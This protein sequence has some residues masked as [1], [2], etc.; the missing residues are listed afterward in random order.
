MEELEQERR[1]SPL[2]PVV[3]GGALVV[4]IGLLARRKGETTAE[5]GSPEVER[6]AM[7][8]VMAAERALGREPRDVAADKCGYDIESRVPDTGRLLFIEVKGRTATADTVCI[9]KNEIL[10]ALN[11]PESFIL[12]VVPVDEAGAQEPRYI[13]EPFQREPDFGVTSVNYKL[14]ELLSRAERPS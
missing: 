1:L 13:R 3:I 7:E 11:K 10:T 5:G 6:L 8:A 2:P 14:A 4:P 9:T 12:A